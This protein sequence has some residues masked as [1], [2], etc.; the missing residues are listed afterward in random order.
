MTT[1]RYFL[2]RVALAFG[3]N[4]RQNRMAD[5]ASETHL[6]REAEQIL[7]ERIWEN[8]EDVEELGIEYWNLRRLFSEKERLQKDLAK[9]QE[10]LTEAHEQRAALLS[11]R[12]VEQDHLEEARRDRISELET[13]AHSRDT[14]VTKAREVRRLYDGLKTKLEVLKEESREES[15]VLEKTKTRMAELRSS[16]EKLKADRDRIARE[17]KT[18]DTKLNDI[19]K[20]LDAE[21][22]RHRD[23][24]AGA[25]Q[26]IGDANRAISEYKA[27]LGLIE[28]RMQQL[29]GEIGRHVSRH[30]LVDPGC[31][32]AVH[33]QR[34][35]VDVMA[36]LRKSIKLNH[37]LTGN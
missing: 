15:D 22:K 32:S 13:L 26:Q 2:A 5:A 25:F 12:S 27:E 19:D 31:R 11:E 3:I 37:R 28:T 33:T 24:A 14:V 8:V 9:S 6:L 23:E 35:M 4:R 17:I 20:Q 1:T 30:A 16:F 10:I 21:R 34:P 36:Q 29:F 7:G 18:F